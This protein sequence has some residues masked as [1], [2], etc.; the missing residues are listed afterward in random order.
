MTIGMCLCDVHLYRAFTVE[1][2][3]W[4]LSG[5]TNQVISNLNFHWRQVALFGPTPRFEQ[6]MN[7]IHQGGL[8]NN[9][10]DDTH[11]CSVLLV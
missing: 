1:K 2:I 8:H 7:L 5:K 4:L 10:N 6:N 3:C 11:T 9:N